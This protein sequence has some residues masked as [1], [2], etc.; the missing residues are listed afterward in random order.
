M[1]PSITLHFGGISSPITPLLVKLAKKFFD[2]GKHHHQMWTFCF[3]SLFPPPP[4]PQSVGAFYHVITEQKI[5]L[6]THVSGVIFVTI[7]LY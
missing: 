3:P 7:Y 6:L 4:S 2:A 5:L 1:Y